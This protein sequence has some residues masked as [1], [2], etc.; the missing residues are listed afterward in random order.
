MIK[1]HPCFSELL[2]NVTTCIKID[3]AQNVLAEEWDNVC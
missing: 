1:A 2:L 3:N